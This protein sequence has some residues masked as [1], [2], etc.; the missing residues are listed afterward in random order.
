MMHLPFLLLALVA[1]DGGGPG[2]TDDTGDTEV[3]TSD[4]PTTAIPPRVR[5]VHLAPGM[6]SGCDLDG[7]T[8]TTADRYAACIVLF[9]GEGQTP[10]DDSAFPFGASSAFLPL[11]I[12]GEY[13][14]HAIPYNYFLTHPD[15]PNIDDARV[16]SFDLTVLP[17]TVQTFVA[18]GHPGYA[19]T[20]VAVFVDDALV[21]P[22]TGKARLRVFHGAFAASAAVPDVILGATPIATDLAY[23]TISA[24]VEVDPGED[25]TVLMDITGDG[26]PDL[27]ALADLAADTVYDLFLVNVPPTTVPSGFLGFLHTPTSQVPALVPFGPVP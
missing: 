21:P 6:T 15:S 27:V 1:C 17:E 13:A 8:G 10:L 7:D 5:G 19:N 22:T 4:L 23:A 14:F 20:G 11:P 24:G 2:D 12:T 3:E 25:Q 18:Y 9:V 16:A 26:A